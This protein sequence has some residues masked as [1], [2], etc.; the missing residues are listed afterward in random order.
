MEGPSLLLAFCAAMFAGAYIAGVV[1]LRIS[2]NA[3]RLRLIT[4]FGAGLLVGTALIVII[5]EGVAMHYQSQLSHPHEAEA[6][7]A[8]P[9]G[10]KLAEGGSKRLLTQVAEAVLPDAASGTVSDA[11]PRALAAEHDHSEAGHDHSEGTD[12]SSAGGSHAGHTHTAGQ[13]QIGA[14]LSLGF[15]F[16]VVVGA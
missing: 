2:V 8:L 14:A 11:R 13:W 16:Q 10:V 6:P 5:P 3:S 12:D 4:I 1:P 15:A 7:A 9:P